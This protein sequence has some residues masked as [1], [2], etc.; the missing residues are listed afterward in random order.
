MNYVWRLLSIILLNYAKRVD[1]SQH[2]STAAS[3]PNYVRWC[4]ICKHEIHSIAN[5]V[6]GKSCLL[7]WFSCFFK[8]VWTENIRRNFIISSSTHYATE[9][10]QFVSRPTNPNL[11]LYKLDLYKATKFAANPYNLL[12]KSFYYLEYFNSRPT[13]WSQRR[14]NGFN[15]DSALKIYFA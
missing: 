14:S 1:D 9:T 7:A 13:V 15:F 11:D 12:L 6:E 2:C 10:V 8:R 5:L 3:R 4:C